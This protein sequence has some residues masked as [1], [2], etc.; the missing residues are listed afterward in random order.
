MGESSNVPR[1]VS[2][3]I[4]NKS[5][6]DTLNYNFNLDDVMGI[7]DKIFKNNVDDFKI[8]E[9]NDIKNL[10]FRKYK[11]NQR[12]YDFMYESFKDYCKL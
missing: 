11:F 6:S 2:D 5:L 8:E 10:E 7:F 3:K 4:L 1:N 9:N 12:N